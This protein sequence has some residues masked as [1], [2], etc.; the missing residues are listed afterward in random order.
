MSIVELP[1][2]DMYWANDCVFGQFFIAKIMP[3]DKY[4]RIS[5]YFHLNDNTKNP[6]KGTKGHDKLHHCRPVIA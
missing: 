6:A 5:Q 3:R 1:K 2:S 4:D